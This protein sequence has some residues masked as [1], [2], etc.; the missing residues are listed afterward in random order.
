[1]DDVFLKFLIFTQEKQR[2]TDLCDDRDVQRLEIAGE[3]DFQITFF[4]LKR[5]KRQK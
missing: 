2:A 3:L 5:Q 4:F 1:M